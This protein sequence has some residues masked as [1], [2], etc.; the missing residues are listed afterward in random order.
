MEIICPSKHMKKKNGEFAEV[1]DSIK[2][3]LLEIDKNKARLIV[4]HTAT[5]S[6]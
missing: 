3:K 4:S 6:N 1:N 5:L 2:F